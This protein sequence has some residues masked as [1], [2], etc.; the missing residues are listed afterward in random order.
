M[1]SSTNTN[2]PS[3]VVSVSDEKSVSKV[4]M[5]HTQYED[6]ASITVS[7]SITTDKIPSGLHI[8]R[9]YIHGRALSGMWCFGVLEACKQLVRRGLLSIGCLHGYSF[10]ALAALFFVC[11]IS[12]P[13]CLVVYRELNRIM[14]VRNSKIVPSAIQLLATLLPDDA[15]IQCRNK[16][17]IGYTETFPYM[18]YKEKTV[19]TSN[20]ELMEYVNYSMTVPGITTPLET[21]RSP[22]IDGAIGNAIWGWGK[23]RPPGP[24]DSR[25]VRDFTLFSVPIPIPF[26]VELFSPWFFYSYLLQASDPNVDL[27]IARG[28]IDLLRF[29][30]TGTD[31]EHVKRRYDS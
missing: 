23:T 9:M 25:D 24:T 14:S 1:M 12:L 3:D 30:A 11:D 8:S 5:H 29:L 6:D 26:E 7:Y 19:F 16:V 15:Y 4:S 22:Y 28:T 13:Q 27:L 31:S 21:I 10:G 17:Y 20:E 2:R 18:A